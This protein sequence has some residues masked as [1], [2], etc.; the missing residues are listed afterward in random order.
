MVTAMKWT[1]LF[2]CCLSLAG[3]AELT[4]GR[5]VYLMPMGRGLDQFIANR[6][7]RMH[8]FQVVTD[9][10]K[11]DTVIS[12]RV[13]RELEDRLNDLYPPPEEP[14]SGEAAPAS[15]EAVRSKPEA[16]RQQAAA[17]PSKPEVPQ[18]PD[19]QLQPSAVAGFAGD[20][21]NKPDKRGYM[22]TS[23][24]S[25][26][27]I[28]LVDVKSRQVLWSLF[29]TPKNSSPRELDRTAQKIVKRLKE[30]LAAK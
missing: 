9:P 19:E 10:S 13:G 17:P 20:T 21:A 12:D 27:V 7:T 2:F 15:K 4:E 8:V 24:H 14:K 6:L 3:A 11:A 1:T 5:T 23:G 22:G 25:R 28:F 29:E 18:G 30:D 16:A 26:G